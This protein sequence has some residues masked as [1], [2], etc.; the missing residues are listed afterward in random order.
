MRNLIDHAKNEFIAA[1]YKP[2]EQE[3]PGP[4]KWIQENIIELLEVFSKQGHSGLSA[5]YCIGMFE[6]LA[7][8]EP[9]VPLTGKDEEWM[10][11]GD[12]IFQNKRCLHVFKQ[13]DRFN[14]QAYDINGRI[15]RDPNG[16]CYTSSDSCVPVT[17]PYTPQSEYVDVP[18]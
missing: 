16:L 18:E 11:V 6:R 1:G 4:N 14:G 5:M 9:L 8:F 7:K 17:F 3:E 13:K 15:F 12:N 2:I 10:E